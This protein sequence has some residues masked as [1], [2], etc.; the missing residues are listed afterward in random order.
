MF[1]CI[2]VTAKD[3]FSPTRQVSVK[4]MCMLLAIRVRYRPTGSALLSALSISV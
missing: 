1:Y 3:I 2:T 4:T